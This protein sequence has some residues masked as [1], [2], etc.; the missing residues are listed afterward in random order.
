[1]GSR[2]FKERGSICT[3]RRW[4]STV[5]NT[6]LRFKGRLK[7]RDQGTRWVHPHRQWLLHQNANGQNQG[8]E[9]SRRRGKLVREWQSLIKAKKNTRVIATR[10]YMTLKKS[11]PRGAKHIQ[12]LK[13]KITKR[14]SRT[15]PLKLSSVKS[16]SQGKTSKFLLPPAR[17]AEEPTTHRPLKNSAN[18]S[19]TISSSMGS[20]S[21]NICLQTHPRRTYLSKLRMTP[22]QR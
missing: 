9:W 13:F 14:I 18:C 12:G 6:R 19:K 16:Q 22:S 1:M 17:A 5:V 7:L 20:S 15:I 2:K 3:T 8:K 10:D 4:W 21:S 11:L